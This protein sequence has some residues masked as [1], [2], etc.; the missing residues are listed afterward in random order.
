MSSKHYER[1][2]FYNM[3][4]IN[5][6]INYCDN[7][8]IAEE[9]LFTKMLKKHN[10]RKQARLKVKEEQHQAFIEHKKQAIPYVRKIATEFVKIYN[11]SAGSKI[12]EI[13]DYDIEDFDDRYSVIITLDSNEFDHDAL[14]SAISYIETKYGTIMDQYRITLF[15]EFGG[16]WVSV[17]TDEWSFNSKKWSKDDRFAN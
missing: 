1:R 3:S 11:D 9:G 13:N 5:E 15:T 16:P 8:I 4:D 10:E 7:M 12:M 17:E 14:G 2:I 6:F